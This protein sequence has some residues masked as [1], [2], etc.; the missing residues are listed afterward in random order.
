MTSAPFA[1]VRY[2]H[3]KEAFRVVR[4]LDGVVETTS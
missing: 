1:F 3:K 4:N 2:G